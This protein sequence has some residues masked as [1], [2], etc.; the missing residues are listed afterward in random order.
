M[1]WIYFGFL[2]QYFEIKIILLT[3]QLT[4]HPYFHTRV[5]SL[6]VAWSR[7][8]TNAMC[9]WGPVIFRDAGI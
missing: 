4:F 3:Y 5:M 6:G 1:E 8:N 2:L 9:C 7:S